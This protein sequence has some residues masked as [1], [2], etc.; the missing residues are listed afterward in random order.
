[1]IWK[2]KRVSRVKTIHHRQRNLKNYNRSNHASI[3]PSP[4]GHSPTQTCLICWIIN[5]F[6]S[7]NRR[8][9][10]K[11]YTRR[12]FSIMMYEF[13]FS[14]DSLEKIYWDQSSK[15]ILTD[16]FILKRN[17]KKLHF[18]SY[19][20]VESVSEWIFQFYSLRQIW[21]EPLPVTEMIFNYTII[22]T[23]ND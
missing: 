14:C 20:P 17:S 7:A 12:H 9:R 19:C 5:A 8:R 23:L 11:I 18:E 6:W 1:M 10:K 3:F 21:A 13:F 22:L 15:T 16:V 4:Y 2:A